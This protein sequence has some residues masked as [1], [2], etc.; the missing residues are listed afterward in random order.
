MKTNRFFIF[1][2]VAFMTLLSSCNKG[3]DPVPFPTFEGKVIV[4]NEGN[5][6][7]QSGS[8]SLYNENTGEMKNRAFE[9][10]NGFSIGASIVSASVAPSGHALLVCNNPNKIV[11][12]DPRNMKSAFT[13]I[14]QHVSNPRNTIVANGRVLVTNW[15]TD[16]IVNEFGFWEFNKS[17]ISVYDAMNLDYI[18]KFEVG[19]DVEGIV[20]YGSKIFVATKEGVKVYEGFDD[21]F[22]LLTTISL[23]GGAAAKHFTFDKM[24]NLWASFP[25]VGVVQIN[26]ESLT[27]EKIVSVPVD[28]MSGYISGDGDKVY[29]FNTVYDNNY[30]PVESTIYAV[31]IL[32]G[33]VS[34]FYKGSQFYGIG[35]SPKTGNIFTAEVSFTSN[36]V[37][38]VVGKNGMEVNSRA[39]GIGTNR[40]LFY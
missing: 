28:F 38:K 18:K 25:A 32:S 34:E 1:L 6:S 40:F 10:A 26:P 39:A 22:R 27:V 13:P 30:M 19:T 8:I 5:F 17:Y 33:A 14:T 7:E 21:S 23:E 31:D 3:D 36:S 9:D 15:G 4:I 16:Y 35:V 2:A 20:S 11:I 37:M 29:T 24:A 12:V